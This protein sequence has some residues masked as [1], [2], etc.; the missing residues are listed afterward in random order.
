MT[1]RNKNIIKKKLVDTI[2]F[3]SKMLTKFRSMHYFYQL[4]AI[5]SFLVFLVMVWFL[6]QVV[7]V[8]GQR[9]YMDDSSDGTDAMESVSIDVDIG[10]CIGFRRLLDGVCVDF[11]EDINPRLVGVM[12]ENHIEAR[13]LSGL[14]RA[15]V[16]Y[17]APVEGNI[18]R[19]LALFS[20]DSTVSKVG[21]VRSSRPYYLDWISEYGGAMNMHVGGSPEA[22]EIIIDNR[23]IFDINEFNRG[24]Y[25]YR[26]KDRMAP[27]N[28]YTSSKLWVEAWDRY[29]D[30]QRPFDSWVYSDGDVCESECVSEI[31]PV[32]LRRVYEPTWRFSSS[33]GQYARYEYGDRV[34]DPETGEGI[35]ANTIIVQKVDTTVIDTVGRKKVSTIG[36]GDAI[37]FRNGRFIS[38]FWKKDSRTG[39]T[40]WLDAEGVD[41]PLEPGKIWII[42]LDNDATLEMN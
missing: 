10:G 11:V 33:S 34:V 23:D 41:I 42:V 8:A 29:G 3:V 16:V 32:F 35:M 4:S 2:V 6:L 36:G 14:S 22:L 25:F 18:T 37:I 24:W 13:P 26:S 15:R 31:S 27:H 28:T 9:L 17:E 40:V 39:R 19:F 20:V 38:G 1:K 5:V 21:P 7:S 30:E 12:I